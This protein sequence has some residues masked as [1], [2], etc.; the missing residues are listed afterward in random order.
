MI[1]VGGWRCHDD[2]EVRWGDSQPV[3]PVLGR[4]GKFGPILDRELPVIVDLCLGENEF[5]KCSSHGGAES[6]EGWTE[7]EIFLIFKS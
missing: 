3:V 2:G 1:L 5:G 4:R 6:V 7:S